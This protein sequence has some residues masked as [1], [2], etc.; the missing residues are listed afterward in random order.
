[1]PPPL[2]AAA[3]FGLSYRPATEADL[4][5]LGR[6]YASTREDEVAQAGWPPELQRA[7]LQQQH[8]AQHAYYAQTYAGAE[9]LVIEQ[10]GE[11]VGRLY[12]YEFPGNLRIVDISLL[13]EARGRGWGEAILKDVGEQAAGRGLKVSIHVERFN[14]AKR[15][16]E[17]L[18]FAGV[19]DK[20][21]YVLME[22][23]PG[24]RAEEA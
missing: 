4:P 9:R 15:L 22:W 6:I 16:Y 14:P 23:R 12:L 24:D 8:E 20:G 17:R 1:M 13:P 7:F 11:A 19:E 21:V 18:G 5:L 10:N 2:R 3:R